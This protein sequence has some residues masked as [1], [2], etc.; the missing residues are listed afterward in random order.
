V[1]SLYALTNWSRRTD[2]R[3]STLTELREGMARDLHPGDRYTIWS[4]VADSRSGEAI[5][6]GTYLPT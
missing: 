3:Y 1:A 2:A 4:M 6:D 5:E